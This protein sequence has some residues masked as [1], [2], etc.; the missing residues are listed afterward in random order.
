MCQYRELL[1]W[2][3]ANRTGGARRHACNRRSLGEPVAVSFCSYHS[4][5]PGRCKKRAAY[6]FHEN[7]EVKRLNDTATQQR[8]TSLVVHEPFFAAS[9]HVDASKAHN[10]PERTSARV[11][12]CVQVC[13]SLLW[14][15]SIQSWLRLASRRLFLTTA[16]LVT[17]AHLVVFGRWVLAF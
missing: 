16:F 11:P 4:G 3:A 8:A 5:Y 2:L 12:W 10:F 6:V 9:S 1:E 17:G 13:P 14:G 15:A 7:R